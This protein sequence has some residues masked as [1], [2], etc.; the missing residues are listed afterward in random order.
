M[1]IISVEGVKPTQ[2]VLETF[3]D[4]PEGVD[5]KLINPNEGVMLIGN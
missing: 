2:T 5:N 3:E 1:N 4:A